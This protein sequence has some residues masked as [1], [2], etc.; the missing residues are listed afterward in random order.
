LSSAQ[1][2]LRNLGAIPLPPDVP[3]EETS[4]DFTVGVTPSDAEH[5]GNINISGT[6]TPR[7]SWQFFIDGVQRTVPICLIPVGNLRVPVFVAHLIAGAM[8][9]LDGRLSPFIKREAVILYFPLE[10]IRSAGAGLSTTPFLTDPPFTKLDHTGN[11]YEKI[12]NLQQPSTISFWT[13]ISVKLS[14][15]PQDEPGLHPSG[16]DPSKLSAIGAVRRAARDRSQVLLRIMELG[17]IWEIATK[18][19]LD[20][21]EFM[22]LDGPVFLPFRYAT[23]TSQH[24]ATVMDPMGENIG[25][26]QQIFNILHN[27]IGVV[28]TVQIIPIQ[29]LIDALSPGPGFV[30]PIYVFST[31]VRG[32]SD[33]VSRHTLACFAWLRRELSGEISPIWS[34]SSELVRIDIPY[35]AIVDPKIDNNWYTPEFRPDVLGRHKQ[36]VRDILSTALAERWPI[37]ETTPH[38]MLTELYPIAETERWLRAHLMPEQEL[39]KLAGI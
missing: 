12:I 4:P 25:N 21:N 14:Y 5:L 30:I 11:I 13:D 26:V 8:R 29:G 35:P 22:I 27:L 6:P 28:K 9:R 23:L 2:Y 18:N 34:P 37:P 32:A 1:G 17:I 10:G 24:L 19:I 33:Q 15:N 16:L 3:S 39:R 7:V 36:K 38:R 20:D 31:T